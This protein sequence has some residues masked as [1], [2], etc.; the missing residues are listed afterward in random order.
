MEAMS[1][2]IPKIATNVGGTSE[3]VTDKTGILIPKN[4]S[5][6]DVSEALNSISKKS[7]STDFRMEVRN[8][9]K[10]KVNAQENFTNFAEQLNS[11]SEQNTH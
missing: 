7:R 2:G 1:F 9:W 5:P 3:L 10:S 8:A 6:E 11:I 4:C